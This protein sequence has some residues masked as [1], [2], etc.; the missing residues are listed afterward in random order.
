MENDTAVFQLTHQRL[1]VPR[2]AQNN[3]FSIE[4]AKLS[5]RN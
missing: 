4:A 5:L 3:S 2:S 1:R